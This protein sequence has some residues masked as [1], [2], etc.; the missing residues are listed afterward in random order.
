MEIHGV[1]G[2]PGLRHSEALT[3]MKRYNNLKHEKFI[4]KNIDFF[5]FNP[6]K[7]MCR[8]RR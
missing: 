7:L 6:N 3:K 2:F 4:I 5:S 8:K 1:L